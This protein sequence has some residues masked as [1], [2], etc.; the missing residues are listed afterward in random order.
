MK[1]QNTLLLHVAICTLQC[2]QY[3]VVGDQVKN[4]I[5]GWHLISWDIEIYDNVIETCIYLLSAMRE[6]N[7]CNCKS[8]RFKGMLY[9]MLRDALTQH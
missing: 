4:G 3:D 5:H 9:K 2:Y 6:E 8:M 1:T 7:F